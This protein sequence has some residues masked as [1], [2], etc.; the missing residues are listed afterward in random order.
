MT[1]NA[2][3]I[4]AYAR[5]PFARAGGAL[6]ALPAHRLGALAV[7]ELLR[8]AAVDPEQ[9]DG[10]YAGLGLAAGVRAP[11]RE[12]VLASAL[13]DAT[14]SLAVNRA[15]CSGMT[16]LGLAL[17]E[18]AL[19]TAG[20][21]VCGGCDSASHTP[22]PAQREP[23]AQSAAEALALG[24]SPAMQQA[25]AARSIACF[26]AADEAGYLHAE[27][28]GTEDC[29]T[30]EVTPAGGDAAAAAAHGA[31]AQ[32]AD[33]A[34]FLLLATARK[35]AQLGLEPLAR[36]AGYAQAAGEPALDASVAVAATRQL[37]K[38]EG[39]ALYEID[40]LEINE[41]CAATCLLTALRLGSLNPDIAADIRDRTNLQGGALALGHPP[42]ASGA[43]LVMT[44][45]GALA[46]RG[47]GRGLA[48]IGGGYGQADALMLE[49]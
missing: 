23:P 15:A 24:I 19:G 39:R 3:V 1:E 16:A 21:I 28:F 40:L 38:R 6:S 20:L 36:I 29:A 43:R 5:T 12:I 11:A 44:L 42:G 47:G 34:A 46:R 32:A 48:C 17:R 10:L 13:A 41:D 35:A 14:P 45:A 49:V 27:R 25:W 4:V 8:R 22:L 18:L 2:V 31:T 9:V 30:D 26:R 7:D 37:M 33:G